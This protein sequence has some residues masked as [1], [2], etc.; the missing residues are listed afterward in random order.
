MF[1]TLTHSV[2]ADQRKCD[3]LLSGK[4]AV[5]LHFRLDDKTAA[6]RRGEANERT[7]ASVRPAVPTATVGP[8]GGGGT[9][10]VSRATTQ[11]SNRTTVPSV[12]N[13]DPLPDKDVFAPE[14]ASAAPLDEERYD[15][16]FEALRD[17]REM[18]AKKQGSKTG[19]S[20]QPFTIIPDRLLDELARN[21]PPTY[22]A[23]DKAQVDGRWKDLRE[24][25]FLRNHKAVVWRAL[26]NGFAAQKGEPPPH[27]MFSPPPQTRPSQAPNFAEFGFN[28]TP[29]NGNG[30]AQWQRAGNQKQQGQGQQGQQGQH[31]QGQQGR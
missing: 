22:A 16:L 21:P 28:G 18:L 15:F 13:V 7:H 5:A 31:G 10:G 17:A 9:G 2:H 20:I 30:G 27:E 19:T 1:S 6:Y 14:N 3:G 4:L 25:L 23:L 29:N 24:G 12:T 26:E 11:N 8:G